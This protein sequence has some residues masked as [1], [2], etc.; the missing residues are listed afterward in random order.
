MSLRPWPHRSVSSKKLLQRTRSKGTQAVP[1]AAKSIY[2]TNEASSSGAADA[3][4]NMSLAPNAK[5]RSRDEEDDLDAEATQRSMKSPRLDH[6]V[7]DSTS[8]GANQ[9]VDANDWVAMLPELDALMPQTN[10]SDDLMPRA[11]HMADFEIDNFDPTLPFG[12]TPAFD[13]SAFDPTLPF[14]GSSFDD[15]QAELSAWANQAYAAD[16]GARA[17]DWMFAEGDGAGAGNDIDA[18]HGGAE[19]EF[20]KIDGGASES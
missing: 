3:S 5:K 15:A 16:S 14:D 7:L 17:D 12:S 4:G 8:V 10:G 1:K 13:E 19:E 6:A 2:T 18:T 11:L 9:V 20:E